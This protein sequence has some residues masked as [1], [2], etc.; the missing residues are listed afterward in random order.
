MV[1]MLHRCQSSRMAGYLLDETDQ[2][3]ILR[4]PEMLERLNE[5]DKMDKE[6]KS[7]SHILY[8][9]DAFIKS[10]T[11]KYCFLPS[12]QNFLFYWN[13]LHIVR[14]NLIGHR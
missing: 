14:I 2:E 13:E 7:K 12:S 11:Q 3:N 8:A 6:D 4:D 5:I 9:I 10:T 1:L